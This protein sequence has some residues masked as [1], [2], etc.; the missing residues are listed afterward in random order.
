MLFLRFRFV[1]ESTLDTIIDAQRECHF[2]ATA[3]VCACRDRLQAVAA[4]ATI[5]LILYID[6]PI[7]MDRYQA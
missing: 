1:L 2:E 4:S 3:Y 5:Y 7:L 6:S